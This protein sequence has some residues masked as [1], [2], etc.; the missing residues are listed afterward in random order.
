MAIVIPSAASSRILALMGV[1]L[2]C[3]LSSAH[4][5]GT[6]S[7]DREADPLKRRAKVS[8]S[9]A[10]KIQTKE[11][12]KETKRRVPVT[13]P[14][15]S[16][17]MP[18]VRQ[19]ARPVS[20][21][22]PLVAAAVLPEAPKAA[23]KVAEPLAE[24][25][26][27]QGAD[28][29]GGAGVSLSLPHILEMALQAHPGVQAARLDLRASQ[30]D[31]Q[32]TERQRWP[33][34]STVIE[35]KSGN[36]D[37]SSTRLVRLEQNLL[38]GGRTSARIREAQTNVTVNAV[39]VTLTAQ[40]LGLQIVNAW[41][42]L[43]AADGRVRVAS[44]TLD[45]LQDYRQQMLRRVQFEASPAIDLELVVSRLL[46]TEVELTQAQNSRMVALTRLEQY[47]GLKDLAAATLA[48]IRMPGL[49]QTQ[50]M[51]SWLAEVD[52]SLAAGRHPQVQKARQDAMAAQER[53]AAKKAEQY[54]QLYLRVDQPIHATNND[55]T[56]FVGLRYTPG[57]GFSTAVEA[58]ALASRAAS[59][60]QAVDSALREA[61][62][63]LLNDRDEFNSS[64]IRMQALEKA[65][66]G[67]E[68]VLQSYGRQFN[69]SRKTW[70]D[71]MNAVREL[72]QNQYALVDSQASMN[73]ALYRLQVRMGEPVQPAP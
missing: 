15:R 32:A 20:G 1:G 65:V 43:M 22:A 39:R 60:E 24:D 56:G 5:L 38:D 55:L 13:A 3:L 58:Q 12:H 67:S 40:Q 49:S 51:S 2:V 30:E 68:A 36:P 50:S 42:S 59:L 27:S 45:K 73:A 23:I 66:K 26:M 16:K 70:L 69:A 46:Q 9:V 61:T 54:P 44:Q 18:V 6:V 21:V 63:N 52:W 8:A 33:T 41:Q 19:A 31:Q 37:V 4:V 10:S 47:T 35:N 17:A 62:E 57:A 11:R 71:L 28:K 34:L 64:R 48:P 7:A 53:I 14:L 29:A 72:A 25:S